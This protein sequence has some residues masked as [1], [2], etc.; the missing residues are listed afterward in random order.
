MNR[1]FLL[2]MMLAAAPPAGKLLITGSSTLTPMI[3]EIAKRFTASHP[4]V[5]IS[6]SAEVLPCAAEVRREGLA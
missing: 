5:S 4:G 6:G 1:A 2:C 3:A